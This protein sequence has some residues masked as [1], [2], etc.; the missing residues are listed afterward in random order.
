MNFKKIFIILSGFQL[1]WLSCIFGQYFSI[2]LLGV[3]IG[4]LYLLFFF[5]LNKDRK[6]TLKIIIFISLIGC[7]FDNLLSFFGIFVINSKYTLI[8]IPI[9]LIIL[10]LC[11]SSLFVEVFLFLKNRPIISFLL[12]FFL[13]PPTYY[14]GIVLNIAN[15]SSLITAMSLMAFFWGLLFFF[16]SKFK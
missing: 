2:P 11:F 14:V 12:G 16:Y 10:W 7:I 3:F 8:Y 4:I 15:S 13:V 6:N 9:W 1:T 5:Y